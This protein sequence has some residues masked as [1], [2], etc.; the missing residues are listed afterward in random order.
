MIRADNKTMIRGLERETAQHIG[1]FELMK[2]GEWGR[3]DRH[4]VLA[5]A[6]RSGNGNSA[7]GFIQPPVTGVGHQVIVASDGVEVRALDDNRQVR[8]N[9]A[10]DGKLVTRLEAAVGRKLLRDQFVPK[11]H[12]AVP[13]II[14][15]SMFLP[16]KLVGVVKIAI[17]FGFSPGRDIHVIQE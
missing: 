13:R 14:I 16:N 5:D 6:G 4:D 10:L 8:W 11:L 17:R 12:G 15:E 2:H 3:L 1:W 7:K 9:L